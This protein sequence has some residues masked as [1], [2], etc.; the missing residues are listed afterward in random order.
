M[1]GMC[2]L[3]LLA[4]DIHARTLQDE[5]HERLAMQEEAAGLESPSIGE[6]LT[7]R[8]ADRAEKFFDCVLEDALE[9]QE[10]AIDSASCRDRVAA[11]SEH[12]V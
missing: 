6:E 8:L 9:T 7:S 1:R 11:G 12:P 5:L 10:L 4:P 2:M 3:S